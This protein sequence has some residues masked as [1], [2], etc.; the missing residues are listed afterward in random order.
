MPQRLHKGV[1]ACRIS[2]DH[3]QIL[4]GSLESRDE[5]SSS[6]L[7]LC[8][9]AHHPCQLP[10]P[11]TRGPRPARLPAS[12]PADLRI[13]A[14][15][16]ISSS[17]INQPRSLAALNEQPVP[18]A[19]TTSSPLPGRLPCF[20]AQCNAGAC[21]QLAPPNSSQGGFSNDLISPGEQALILPG[22]QEERN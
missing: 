10:L 8:S 21:L 20:M 2:R 1:F 9:R 11:R 13:S 5:G 17:V 6:S 14:M 18:S 22:W 12:L 4:D 16:F 7:P 15:L 3:L 19:P